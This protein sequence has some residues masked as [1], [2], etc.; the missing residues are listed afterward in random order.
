MCVWGFLCVSEDLWRFVVCE[1]EQLSHVLYTDFVLQHQELAF[2]HVAITIATFHILLHNSK[3]SVSS[4][5]PCRF[6]KS[7]AC[8]TELVSTQRVSFVVLW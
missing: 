8:A 5:M 2:L 7:A 4:S 3:T 6:K 1:S